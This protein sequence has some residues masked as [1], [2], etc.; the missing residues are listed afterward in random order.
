MIKKVGDGKRQL[1]TKDGSRPLGP[2]TTKK[3]ARA[4]EA[5]IKISEAKAAKKGGK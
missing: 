4:Q 1:F 5:A 3:K 2:K